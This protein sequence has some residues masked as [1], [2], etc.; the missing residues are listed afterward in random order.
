MRAKTAVAVL[1]LLAV[2][3]FSVPAARAA[4]P[5][6]WGAIKAQYRGAAMTE[7]IAVPGTENNNEIPCDDCD[8]GGGYSNTNY[9][10]Q[11]Q[12]LPFGVA[13]TESQV[14]TSAHSFAAAQ[15]ALSDYIARGYIRRT[16]LDRA[17]VDGQ[18]AVAILAFEMPGQALTAKEPVVLIHTFTAGETY[19][20][21]VLGGVVARAIDGSLHFEYDNANPN[22]PSIYVSG[23]IVGS[24]GQVMNATWPTPT[25]DSGGF[26][27][28]FQSAYDLHNGT[29]P[30]GATWQFATGHSPCFWGNAGAEIGVT[31]MAAA[32]EGPISWAMWGLTATLNIHLTGQF[33]PGTSCP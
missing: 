18:G 19:A 4:S 21:Q 7:R 32:T 11:P 22:D 14:L 28:A 27:L 2:A 26:A 15:P 25:L 33:G 8:D 24:N 6:T 23:E 13:I 3:V 1:C 17:K 9:H 29:F 5:T 12:S 31:M 20:T 30:S 10:G 16:D